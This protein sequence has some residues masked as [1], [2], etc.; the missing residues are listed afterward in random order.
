MDSVVGVLIG[1]L[2]VDLGEEILIED[3]VLEGVFTVGLE[4]G[5]IIVV[6]VEDFTMVG[7]EGAFTINQ[8]IKIK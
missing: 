7:S 8:N 3:S 4:R 6:L 5:F 1:A 2:I